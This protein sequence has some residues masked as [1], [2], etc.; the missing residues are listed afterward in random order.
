MVSTL[1]S[2]EAGRARCAYLPDALTVAGI[3]RHTGVEVQEIALLGDFSAGGQAEGF[4]TGAQTVTG[5]FPGAL[6]DDVIAVFDTVVEMAAAGAAERGVVEAGGTEGFGEIFLKGV[7]GFEVFSEGRVFV[8]VGGEEEHLIAAVHKAGDLL[9][10][11]DAMFGDF[12][13]AI[14]DLFDDGGAAFAGDQMP[15]G[16]AF[17][18]EALC[19][20][21]GQAIGEG[22]DFFG[23]ELEE[24][25]SLL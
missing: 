23:G 10:A 8:A 17:G 12:G 19:F 16:D 5:L 1:R 11:E 24:H 9:A 6:G 21:S 7:D 15:A 20:R 13:L 4:G 14:G 25:V 2:G 18:G 22:G 3:Q